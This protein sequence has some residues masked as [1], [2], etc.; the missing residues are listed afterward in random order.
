MNAVENSTL[1]APSLSLAAQ[2]REAAAARPGDVLEAERLAR[3]V[4]GQLK[5]AGPAAARLHQVE[6]AGLARLIED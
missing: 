6:Q 4:A 2:M 5:E 3:Q 1:G